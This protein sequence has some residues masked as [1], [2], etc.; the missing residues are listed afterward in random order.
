MKKFHI[1]KG[2]KVKVISG[3]HKDSEGVVLR[4]VTEKDRAVVEGVNL[5]H[6]HNKPSAQNPQGGIVKR[7]APLHISNLML[8]DP[9]TGEATRTGRTKDEN[10][11]SVR[12]SK[13][14]KEV[15]K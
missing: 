2:D 15:I 3:A 12:Y 9:A 8:I 13:K 11:K 4:V 7:E 14:T 10:G 6:R 1:K 5:I